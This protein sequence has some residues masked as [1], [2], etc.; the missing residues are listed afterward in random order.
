[1]NIPRVTH[2]DKQNLN[3]RE[4]GFRTW[5]NRL[6]HEYVKV[7]VHGQKGRGS[8]DVERIKQLERLGFIFRK[9]S[10]QKGTNQSDIDGNSNQ[11]NKTTSRNSSANNNSSTVTN[12]TK[13]TVRATA[14]RTRG[15]LPLTQ[16]RRG[17]RIR[18]ETRTFAH[19]SESSGDDSSIEAAEDSSDNNAVDDEE[20]IEEEAEARDEPRQQQQQQ[21][22]HQQPQ[23]IPYQQNNNI[24]NNDSLGFVANFLNYHRNGF[25]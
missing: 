23:Q 25:I 22:Q 9:Q 16:H 15:H 14:N 3:P 18:I 19:A 5:A 10:T 17:K 24:N 11:C 6:Q 8:F 1:M 2:E 20:D 7:M 12:A 21:Q 4:L 13:M